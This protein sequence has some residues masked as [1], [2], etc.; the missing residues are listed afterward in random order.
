MIMKA[1]NDTVSVISAWTCYF[2]SS[3]CEIPGSATVLGWWALVYRNDTASLLLLHLGLF[4]SLSVNYILSVRSQ[5]SVETVPGTARRSNSWSSAPC[6]SLKAAAASPAETPEGKGAE[7]GA[8]AATRREACGEPGY[9][10]E[11]TS[12]DLKPRSPPFLPP[13]LSSMISLGT[14]G[15]Y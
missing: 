9:V 7:G 10:R 1:V 3:V 8:G 13:P 11:G 12:G 2:S 4:F 15:G 6:L 14:R 5:E